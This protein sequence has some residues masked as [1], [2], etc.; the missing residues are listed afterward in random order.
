MAYRVYDTEEKKWLKANIYLSPNDEL[1]LIKRGLFGTIKVPLA[2][3]ADR[4][5][6]H[7]DINLYDKRNNLVYEGDFIRAHVAEDK[8]AVGL[9]VYA[10]ELSAYVILCVDSDEFY[11][12]GSEVSSEIEVIGNV[13]DGYKEEKKDGKQALSESKE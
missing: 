3:D 13:F 9:V 2:L 6:F 11:T 8:E 10:H 12:L 4:Y 1:F 5:V 7:K